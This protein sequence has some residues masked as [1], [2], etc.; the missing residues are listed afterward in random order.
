M[1]NNPTGDQ[2]VYN[3]KRRRWWR[4]CHILRCCADRDTR[5]ITWVTQDEIAAAI[6]CS[7]RTVR[8]CVAWL[9]DE[10]LLGLSRS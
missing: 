2:F 10:G 1:S 7:T 9:R 3:A 8:R 5:P 4:I 6:G